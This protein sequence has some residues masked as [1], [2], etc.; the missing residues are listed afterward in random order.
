[1]GVDTTPVTSSL[2][3]LLLLAILPGADGPSAVIPG[4]GVE[5]ELR[6]GRAQVVEGGAVAVLT[7]SA[8]S[9]VLVGPTLVEVGARSEALVTWRG[10]GSLRVRGK[11]AFH[12]AQERAEPDESDESDEL[13]ENDETVAE[14]EDGP[15][16]P[17][18]SL[19]FLRSAEVELRRGALR[20]D[21]PRGFTLDLDRA[22]LALR[23]FADGRVEV[24]HRG[25]LPVRIRR[26]DGTGTKPILLTSGRSVVLGWQPRR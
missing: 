3:L 11:A 26:T 6:S 4:P 1:M 24:T 23:E 5:L 22:A 19:S 8:P 16:T 13:A 17:R 25:G 14:E 12:V 20:L 10:I 9:R 18:V 15:T 7:S 2:A 21:L